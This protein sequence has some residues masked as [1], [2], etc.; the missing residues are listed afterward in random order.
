MVVVAFVATTAP[1]AHLLELPNKLSL[2][3][4]SW[5]LVQQRLYRGWG[6]VFGPVE[7]VA[8][9]GG[10]ALCALLRDNKPAMRVAL[11]A[12]AL[13]VGMIVVFFVFNAPVNAAF[14]GWTVGTLPPDWPRYR[15]RWERGHALVALLSAVALILVVRACKRATASSLSR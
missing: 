4:P 5:L 7:L 14:N 10:L 6:E 1:I 13:Y 15:V 2:D 8:V 12:V 11:A 9:V 3:G